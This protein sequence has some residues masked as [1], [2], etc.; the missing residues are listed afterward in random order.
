MHKGE[1]CLLENIRFCSEEE[2]NDLGFA[3]NLASCFD[4]YVND[5]FSVSHRNHVSI[6]GIT[7]FLP[8]VAG[9][10]LS[11]EVDNLNKL[12]INPS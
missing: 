8:S 7:K 11:N 1:I 9:L 3:K 6:T 5:A 12:L 10:A 4:V 2:N